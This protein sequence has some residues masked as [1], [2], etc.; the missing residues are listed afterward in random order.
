M[1]LK[2][3]IADDH[4]LLVDGLKQVLE[5]IKNVEVVATAGNGFE[6][7][8]VLRKTSVD[9]VLLD[10]Q[11]P[12]IDGIDSLKIL[13]KD[14]PKLK[15]VVFTNY[16]QLKLIKEI[17]SLGANGYLLK[18]STSTI[19][20][21]AV[22]AVASGKSWYQDLNTEVKQSVLLTN[23]FMKKYQLTEREAEIIGKIAEGLT[24]KEIASQLYVSEFTIN[25]HRRNICRKLN[26]YTPVGLLNFAKEHGL[27]S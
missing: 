10:L 21:E 23:D 26:I 24:T 4:P 27:V 17:K 6:L 25:T 14:F 11:M 3:V 5:E 13:K 12:K 20:K 15:I 1:A 8:N 19:L 16:G 2:L 18:N 9:M 22:N 7:I